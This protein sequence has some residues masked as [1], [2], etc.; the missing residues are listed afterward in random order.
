MDKEEHVRQILMGLA[1]IHYTFRKEKRSK[2][3]TQTKG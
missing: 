2:D 1:G 3:G